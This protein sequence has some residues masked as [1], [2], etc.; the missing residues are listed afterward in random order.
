MSRVLLHPGSC[1]TPEEVMAAERLTG[2]VAV[3]DGGQVVMVPASEAKLDGARR[4]YKF[5]F[6]EPIRVTALPAAPADPRV[7]REPAGCPLPSPAGRGEGG[8]GET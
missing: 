5:R 3:A 4:D 1:H 7:Q 6:L 2:L 8:E